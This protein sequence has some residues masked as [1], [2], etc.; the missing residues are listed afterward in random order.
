MTLLHC[1]FSA[2]AGRWLPELD[3]EW[4][5]LQNNFIKSEDVKEL[6]LATAVRKWRLQEEGPFQ[7]MKFILRISGN[8]GTSMKR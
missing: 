5:N 3:Y 7:D 1:F 6:K 2:Q 8:T 4:G